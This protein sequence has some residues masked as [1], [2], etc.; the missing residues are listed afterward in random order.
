MLNDS[1][2]QQYLDQYNEYKKQQAE[3]PNPS[4]EIDINNEDCKT[5]VFITTSYKGFNY[6]IE[7]IEPE[8]APEVYKYLNGQPIVRAKYAHGKTITED[9]SN[10]RIN[11]LSARFEL[12]EYGKPKDPNLYMLG[13][14]VVRDAED[15]AFLGICNLGAG[16]IKCNSEIA[17]LNRPDAWNNE[18]NQEAMQQYEPK[19][20]AR[21]QKSYNGLGAA[22]VYVLTQYAK[23][24]KDND[25]KINGE[26]LEHVEAVARIDNPGSW[27]AA[28][29]AG[30]EAY[31][32]DQNLNYSE[33]LR[34][35][36]KFKV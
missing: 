7:S 29:K 28:A 1:L 35:Q 8:H 20:Q 13:G 9:A 34:Y 21:L 11:T 12:D 31:D 2:R 33:D 5:K 26:E 30:M 15:D 32:V 14:F 24:L 23:H 19:E 25:Y 18:F 17:Y 10:A 3:N 36:L 4:I 22:E 6:K 16:S 27:K